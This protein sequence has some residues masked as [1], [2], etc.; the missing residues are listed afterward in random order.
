MERGSSPG[1]GRLVV[2]LCQSCGAQPGSAVTP[3]GKPRPPHSA[4]PRPSSLPPPSPRAMG[5][6]PHQRPWE[7]EEGA[8][9]SR[10]QRWWRRGGGA[11]EQ[12]HLLCLPIASQAEPPEFAFARTS[13]LPTPR[14]EA[15]HHPTPVAPARRDRDLRPFHLGARG[16]AP[17]PP[18]RPEPR[19]HH[20]AGLGDVRAEAGAGR[21]G[22]ARDL[23]VAVS[24]PHP[25]PHTRDGSG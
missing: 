11:E 1:V 15:A 22:L 13:V 2:R 24:P 10:Q 14:T 18:P 19:T 16:F 17:F 9:R 7:G 8:S 25:H 12:L 5:L 20:P 6:G 4:L 21:S 23:R 3:T